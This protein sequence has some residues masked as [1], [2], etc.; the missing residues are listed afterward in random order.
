MFLAIA[1]ILAIAIYGFRTT[2]AGRALWQDG[3]EKDGA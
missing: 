2:L 1:L 3:L